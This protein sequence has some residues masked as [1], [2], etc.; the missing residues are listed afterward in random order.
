MGGETT[1]LRRSLL[2]GVIAFGGILAI[3]VG[4]RLEQAALTAVVGVACGVGASIPTSILL[5]ALLQRR[6]AQKE[7]NRRRFA[8]QAPPVVIV[9]PQA[10]SQ[11]LEPNARPDD[12]ALPVPGQRRF[13][14]IG[15][16]EITDV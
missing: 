7:R 4:V 16:D 14:V 11:Y 5:V 12:Y 3:I 9:T 6:R 2:W 8:A 1:S 13:S 15:E 10:A